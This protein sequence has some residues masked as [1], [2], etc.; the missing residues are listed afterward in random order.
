MGALGVAGSDGSQEPQSALVSHPAE[1]EEVVSDAR[2]RGAIGLDTEFMRE[3]TYRAR[4]CLA[5]VAVGER[6]WLIDPL[7]GTDLQ[8]IAELVGESGVEVVLH[9]GKQDLEIFY[10]Y[11]G[12][13][14]KNIFDVQLAAAFAGH[15]ASLPYGRLVEETTGVS[16]TKGESYTDWCRRPLTAS[17]IKYAGDDV[18]Y[19][20]PVAERLREEL[21]ELDRADWVH[22][23]MAALENEAAY[24]FEP[25]D[26]WKRVSGRGT[27][28]P[29][30]MM[31][32]REL[33]SWREEAA[34]R[35]DL[36]R[37]WVMKDAT[38][39]EIARRSPSSAK[40]LSNVR[41]LN[42]KEAE[43][44]GR[45]LLAAVSRGRSLEPM[46]RGPAPSRQI[47]ARARM[48][49]GLADA[50]VRARAEHARLATEL[51]ATRGEL[52]ALL[53]AIFS[54]EVDEGRHR[55]L[56]GW[57]RQIA[58]DAVMALAT[59]EVAVRV[60]DRPPFIEEVGV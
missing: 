41:G 20:V 54:G 5:Q 29:K 49:S 51:V 35:R 34:A 40:E 15:G 7:A 48:V 32:L 24:R 27:L 52:E 45:H 60:T 3:K 17:Q 58:G 23:E 8:P 6:I 55:L 36:P 53:A 22:E 2:A 43:R 13:V 46:E 30:Q 33:A 47:Q 26:A 1:L 21:A 10:E 38:L 50:I 56:Q 44:S 39:V 57:R 59:G 42:P 18:R 25:G 28:K 37:G 11:Y 9:A 19:L 4:L 12:V 14:P 16:L 31:V